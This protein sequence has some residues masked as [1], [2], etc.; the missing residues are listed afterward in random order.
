M[1]HSVRATNYSSTSQTNLII[2]EVKYSVKHFFTD[3][4]NRKAE[5]A[6]LGLNR[7]RASGATKAPKKFSS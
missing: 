5:D 3:L 6:V 4:L 1:T 7:G 2:V